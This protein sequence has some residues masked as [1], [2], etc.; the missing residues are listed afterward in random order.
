[1]S[2][3]Q[4]A[5]NHRPAPD[6]SRY[7]ERGY[8]WP[9]RAFAVDEANRLQERFLEY[10]NENIGRFEG[11]LPRERVSLAIDTHLAL[12]WVSELALHPAV[13][14]AVE[15]VLGPD[16]MIWNTHWFP[17][18]PG[19]GTYVSW[20]Q[21]AA[22][23]GLNPPHVTTAW[24]ALSVSVEQNGCM[25]VV[26][27]SHLKQLPQ[28]ET[29]APSNMLSRG[30]EIA[31]ELDESRALSLELQPGEFSLHHIGIAHGSGSNR[32]GPARIGLAVRYIAP[33]VRQAGSEKD[34]VILAR[35]RDPEHSARLMARPI[36]SHGC[37]QASYSKPPGLDSVV[38]GTNSLPRTETKVLV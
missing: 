14:D 31:V 6:F 21:D 22:Y 8:C 23:W 5:T 20:H 18:F 36:A 17:K 16:V 10:W 34:M 25:R 33:E 9:L 4:H 3:E 30:Q 19:D 12:P 1:M 24:I 2:A 11:R 7:G 29:F 28:I 26:P 37:A 13:L 15:Q 35:G 32:L 27:G 38:L